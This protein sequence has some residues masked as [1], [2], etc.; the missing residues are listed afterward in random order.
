MKKDTIAEIKRLGDLIDETMLAT[1]ILR[2]AQ[3]GH[4]TPLM[5]EQ[6]I[7]LIDKHIAY[8]H[9]IGDQE[10]LKT[11]SHLKGDLEQAL[12]DGVKTLKFIRSRGGEVTEV[13]APLAKARIAAGHK[14]RRQHK[15]AG[16]IIDIY[17]L[18]TDELIECKHRGTSASL[19]EA[20][21][22]LQRYRRSFP[23]TN[24]VI[25]VLAIE[26]DAFWLANLLSQQGIAVIEIKGGGRQ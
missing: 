1:T 20:A 9:E 21:G 8:A 7:E 11:A 2:Y 10:Q 14:I 16:G 17:D 18:T 24:L 22:Q 19:G 23:G 4:A 13:E 26:P 6:A 15:C 3:S 25:A 12:I 5:I